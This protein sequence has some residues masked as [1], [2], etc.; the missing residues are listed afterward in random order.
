MRLHVPAGHAHTT[1]SDGSIVSANSD[2][3]VDVPDSEA[4]ALLAASYAYV[5]DSGV[6][7]LSSSYRPTIGLRPGMQYFDTQIGRLLT[8][9]SQGTWVDGMGRAHTFKGCVRFD[10][11]GS[12]ALG[13]AVLGV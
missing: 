10:Y 9:T 2:G 7:A 8:Y 4:P 13:A 6:G 12:A 3:T 1:L 5:G 11:P